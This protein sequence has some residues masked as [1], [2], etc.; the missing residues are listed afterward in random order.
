[1]FVRPHN[2]YPPPHIFYDNQIYHKL[3]FTLQCDNNL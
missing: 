3:Q 1:M 2:F